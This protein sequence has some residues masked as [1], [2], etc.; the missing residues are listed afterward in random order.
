MADVAEVLAT[1]DALVGVALGA[2]LTYGFSALSRR[3]QEA[4]ED[5]TR[6]YRAR[7]A[8]YTEFHQALSDGWLP[9]GARR[10]TDPKAVSRLRNALGLILLVGSAEVC[11]IALALFGKA[12]NNELGDGQ[13]KVA[14]F[15]FLARRDLGDTLDRSLQREIDRDIDQA[16]PLDE[17][18]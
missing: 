4:R 12:E 2:G 18:D 16:L 7:L 10:R 8:A 6:W 13:P 5:K 9:V 15:L 14:T 11:A 1:Y 3:H 17:D